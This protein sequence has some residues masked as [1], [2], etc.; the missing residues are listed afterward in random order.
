MAYYKSKSLFNQNI[1]SN[2]LL[3][4]SVLLKKKPV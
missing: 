4:N 1:E 3:A 2:L